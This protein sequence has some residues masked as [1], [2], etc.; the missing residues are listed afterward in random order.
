MKLLSRQR[1]LGLGAAIAGGAF[2]AARTL[3]PF[4]LISPQSGL[5]LPK[6]PLM[7]VERP[8]P[9]LVTAQINADEAV[10]SVGDIAASMFTYNKSYPGPLLRLREGERVQLGFTNNLSEH[11]NL[12]LHGVH[13]APDSDDPFWH[14]HP[15]WSKTYF[16]DAPIGS[17]G[18][19]WYHPH[20]H[21]EVA[22][23]MFKG[24]VGAIVTE[25]P[26]DELPELK[27]AEEQV[28]VLTNTTLSG[29]EPPG[30]TFLEIDGKKGDWRL[31]NGALQPVWTAT[32]SNLRLRLINASTARIFN[33]S[34]EGHDLHLI[35]TDGGFIEKPIS[36]KQLELVPGERAE[37]LV[38]FER[39]GTFRLLDGSE[40][41]MS[42]V[43][44]ARPAP[45]PLPDNLAT[46]P[47]LNPAQATLTRRVV[48][49]FAPPY[50]YGINGKMFDPGRVD[51]QAK[52]GNL[53]IWELY[54]AHHQDHPFHLHSY[55]FQVLDRNGTAEPFTA[56]RDVI[57]VKPSETVRIAIP[58]R[59]YT[60][61]TVFHC[62]IGEHEDHGMM[63]VL[64]VVN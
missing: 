10:V 7:A 52:V 45:T 6:L 61:R 3:K 20:P 39:P 57:N 5:A 12:H 27:A 56:W 22:R 14:G 4:S 55:P 31:V 21:G 53:E 13:I 60:G 43:A 40:M 11:T 33:L 18:T 35:A 47:A 37:V 38:Q 44:P 26:L 36:L 51:F 64:E 17:A 16:F 34:L 1:F 46:L 30:Y 59:D 25:G 62:H 24:M 9:G 41:L 50:G 15:G 29:I 54:N 49:D 28:L 23:Q 63:G 2:V 58:F 32:K 8:E 42:I 19:A 48:F